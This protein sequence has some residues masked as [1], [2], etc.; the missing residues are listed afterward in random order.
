MNNVPSVSGGYSLISD[1]DSLGNTPG[2]GRGS[3]V[4]PGTGKDGVAPGD[5]GGVSRAEGVRF[6][7]RVSAPRV[8]GNR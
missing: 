5:F 1:F 3:I 7:S 4:F 8:R 2:T 6:S